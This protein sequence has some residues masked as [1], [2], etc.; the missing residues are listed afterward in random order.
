MEPSSARYLDKLASLRFF[1][2]FLVVIYHLRVITNSYHTAL[3]HAFI[4]MS[5]N[6]YVGVTI[7]FVLSGF[8]IS[9]ANSTWKGWKKYLIGRVARI[10]PPHWISTFTVGLLVL[11]PFYLNHGFTADSWL[12]VFANL[13]LI[14]AWIPDWSYFFS[15]NMVTWSL[16]VEVF[17]Y[18]S[19]L[20]LRRLGDKQLYAFAMASYALLF[21]LTWKFYG[22]WSEY[23]YWGFYINPL[24][25]LPEFLVGMAIYRLYRA[26]KLPT[27]PLQKINFLLILAS[28]LVAMAALDVVTDT[29]LSYR[30]IFSFSV[31]PLPFV[32]LLML[33]LLDERSNIYLHDKR[34]VLLGESSFALYLI[35]RPII[36]AVSSLLEG[37]IQHSAVILITATI[38]LAC[39][40]ILTSVVFYKK[41]EVPITTC[42]RGRLIRI[43][44]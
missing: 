23:V 6:G 2:A 5:S 33:A 4:M 43:A 16:S 34:L 1:A 10:Y 20:L 19:F 44:T 27:L 39:F 32:F 30:N 3:A 35:H 40:T 29:K 18:A 24:A 8:V 13:S 14:H 15:L 21:A 11:I 37:P 17:F 26:K 31:F 28:L 22:T 25:R 12:P 36:V 9:H 38:C 42:L 7:F 41:I